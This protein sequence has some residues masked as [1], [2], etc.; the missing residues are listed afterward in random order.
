MDEKV[1]LSHNPLNKVSKNKLK[2]ANKILS[3]TDMGFYDAVEQKDIA[4]KTLKHDTKNIKKE[5]IKE[6]IYSNKKIPNIWKKRKNFK[7]VVL[8]MFIEDNNFLRYLGS[9]E[10]NDSIKIK[11]KTQIRPKTVSSEKLNLKQK[12][13]LNRTN[14]NDINKQLTV[15]SFESLKYDTK[16]NTTNISLSSY[17]K[18]KKPKIKLKKIISQQEEIQNVFDNLKE[19]YPLSKKLQDL[20]P[21]NYSQ[22]IN[23][24]KNNNKITNMSSVENL[25]DKS[26]LHKIQKIERNIFNN[27]L[28][29]NTKNNLYKYRQYFEKNE[30]NKTNY[31]R[32]SDKIKNK[33]KKEIIKNELNDSSIFNHLKSMNFYGP[34]FSYCPYCCNNN[35]KYYKHMEKKQC[36]SLL[37]YIKIDRNKKLEIEESKFREQVKMNKQ[38]FN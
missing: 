35:I 37:N 20:F 34:Y 2:N 11:N 31:K 4:L 32:F 38:S 1:N 9:G 22:E 14:N 6:F 8:E 21:D 16:S 17:K 5:T 24:G 13:K 36:L 28:S 27:L 18:K 26:R 19:K 33:N 15:G 10:E 3:K 23:K 7:N 25:I 30:N 29:F 12:I